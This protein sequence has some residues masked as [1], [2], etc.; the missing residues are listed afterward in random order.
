MTDIH[1]KKKLANELRKAG[2]IQEALTIYEELWKIANDEF[3]GAG[4]LHCLRK[5]GQYDKA[6]PL[7]GELIKRYPL[8]NWI[9][10]EVIWT[11]ISGR[12]HI[13]ND[14]DITNT[15]SIA[16]EILNFNPDF[17]A[18]KTIIFK[19]L[20]VAKSNKQWDIMTDWIGK[21][22]PEALSQ[23]PKIYSGREGW[24]ER[25]LW[26]YYRLLSF[27]HL[28]KYNE[29]IS[30]VERLGDAF[31][32]QSK[33]FIRC[34]AHAH[35]RLNQF[36]EAKNCYHLLTQLPNPDWWIF[37]EYGK[38]ILDNNDQT[39]LEDAL[40]YMGIAALKCHK[41]ELGVSLYEDIGYLLKKQGSHRESR[42][43]FQ[44]A[45]LIREGNNW[46]V[47]EKIILE[48]KELDSILGEDNRS[49]GF[50][51][52]FSHCQTFWRSVAMPD[53]IRNERPHKRKVRK[54]LRGRVNIGAS[55]RPF[56]FIHSVDK[57]AFFCIKSELP[58][59]VKDGDEVIFD[60][61][62]SYDKK[63]KRILG[64][65]KIS[66]LF[67]IPLFYTPSRLSL[68][69]DA[70]AYPCWSRERVSVGKAWS[71]GETEVQQRGCRLN[72]CHQGA[73]R[74]YQG[75]DGHPDCPV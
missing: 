28:G 33:F 32:K 14:G 67:D 6:I 25:A 74:S 50:Q 44:L 68:I 47:D 26:Y 9:K 34:K 71:D 5:S 52:T 73:G 62:P 61:F 54:D 4:L 24:S 63:K 45:T 22:E 53:Y 43:H 46:H 65:P 13:L 36:K 1:E 37:H 15:L 39:H 10:N 16:H 21:I 70:D 31:P 51:E 41:Y 59:G 55:N 75:S 64:G 18:R 48:I 72:Q 7:A 20:K 8:F 40:R 35:L 3:D 60:G 42:D 19:V 49:G 38:M 12:L 23:D 29:A 11:Y 30:L 57:E 58:H 69:V 27:I 17:L 66:K 2:K 56:C